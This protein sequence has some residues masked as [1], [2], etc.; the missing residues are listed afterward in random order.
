MEQPNEKVNEGFS[1]WRKAKNEISKNDYE[2]PQVY[3]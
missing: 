2:V 3:F 1:L